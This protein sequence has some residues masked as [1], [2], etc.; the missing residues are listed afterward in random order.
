MW[1]EFN[2]IHSHP[3]CHLARRPSL[4]APPL[5]SEWLSAV[6]FRMISV[7]SAH[8]PSE[9][10]SGM[11]EVWVVGGAPP[12]HLLLFYSVQCRTVLQA[13]GQV[14][15]TTKDLSFFS[16]FWQDRDQPSPDQ[17]SCSYH[18][19][20]ML[21]KSVMSHQ[22]KQQ[23]SKI[24]EVTFIQWWVIETAATGSTKTVTG[25]NIYGSSNWTFCP[26]LER[27]KTPTN[28]DFFKIR[29]TYLLAT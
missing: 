10:V 12:F 17:A 11:S 13:A 2:S 19:L 21:C 14:S 27:V 26:V 6:P 15:T 18:S 24:S 1:A 20:C 28:F 7:H 25:K 29:V 23:M 4:C 22:T 9:W 16:G 8:S 3:S 5:T